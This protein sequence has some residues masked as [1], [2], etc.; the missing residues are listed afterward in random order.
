MLRLRREHPRVQPAGRA[1]LRDEVANRCAGGTSLRRRLGPTG[2]D[3][4][5]AALEELDL[6]GRIDPVFLDQ[7]PLL[8]EQGDR[9]VELLLV[10]L[11]G[12]GDTQAGLGF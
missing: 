2:P 9:S 3:D 5:I 11:V 10:Q 6:I 8:L 7:R 12:I 4:D 1:F